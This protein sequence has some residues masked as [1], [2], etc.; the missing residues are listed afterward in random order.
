MNADTVHAVEPGGYDVL[1]LSEAGASSRG[2]LA[3]LV[4][5]DTANS[6]DIN[7]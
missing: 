3:M 2:S 5:H 4:D 7:R 1:L 6:A